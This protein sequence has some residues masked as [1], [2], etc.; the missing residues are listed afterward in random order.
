M[1]STVIPGR[2]RKGN[3]TMRQYLDLLCKVLASGTLHENRT[4]VPTIRITGAMLKFD[5]ADGFPAVTTK[6]LAFN[7]VRGELLGFIRGYT[8]AADFRKLGCHIWDANANDNIAWINNPNR[9]GADDLGRIYGAQWRNWNAS[10]GYIDQLGKAISEIRTNPSSRRIIVNA[11]NPDELDQMA[12][13]PCHILYQ[14]HVDE[15]SGELSMTMY[16]R[17]CDLFLGV[18][19]N[20]ASYALLLHIVAKAC[21]L[22]P[23]EL[24]MFLADTHIYKNHIDQVKEQLMRMPKVLPALILDYDDWNKPL[25]LIEPED[26]MLVDYE[27]HPPIKAP[28]AI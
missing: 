23:R 13:P 17:S 4:G 14:F 9:K 2:W 5:M 3:L 22:I 24:V 8:N 1:P 16:Q 11:W 15:Q 7:Q 27:P 6:R 18:P 12:L 28:M 26:L 21:R 10:D 19:F 20:I 25:E